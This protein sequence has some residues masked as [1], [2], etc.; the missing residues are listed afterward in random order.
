MHRVRIEKI[1]YGGA[2]LAR[3]DGKVVFVPFTAPGD[4]ALIDIE[5]ARNDYLSGTLV[6]LLKAGEGRAEPPCRYFQECGGCQLQHLLHERQ[7]Y[8]KA[9]ILTE[10]LIRGIPGAILPEP[11]FIAGQEWGYRRNVRFHVS[12]SQNP[13]IGFYR[14]KSRWLVDIESCPLLMDALNAA[15]RRLRQSR[16]LDQYVPGKI[17]GIRA[18]YSQKQGRTHFAVL[19][20]GTLRG[21]EPKVLGILADD[22]RKIWEIPVTVSE[23]DACVEE[24]IGPWDYLIHP[25]SFFQSNAHLA[26]ELIRLA[27][28]A[29]RPCGRREQA[30][31]LY[32]G[33]GL[34]TLPLAQLFVQVVAVEQERRSAR[35]AARNAGRSAVHNIQWLRASAEQWIEREARKLAQVDFLL[36]D[37]PREGVSKAVSRWVL[38]AR[39][40]RIV[41]VSCSP[42]TLARDLKRWLAPGPYTL[43]RIVG[44]DLFPQTFHIEAV[45]TLTLQK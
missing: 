24:R 44:L 41:Y 6:S 26:E 7:R 33:I 28:D 20:K 4:E 3:I 22:S 35:E 18:I 36:L 23:E 8:Y 29:G 19:G 10:N 43:E 40:E 13:Q 27:I 38:E 25:L 39:P 14:P 5:E 1:V 45:A 12:D 17:A 37:P 16:L 32:S 2:G 31:E 34:F 15:L 21:E 11:E 9:Q 30:V 42:P